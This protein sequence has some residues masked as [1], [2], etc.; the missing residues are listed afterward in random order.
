MEFTFD[1]ILMDGI[2]DMVFV[3]RV[4]RDPVFIYD[5]L[6]R[7]AMDGT[8][9]N[10][11]AVGK[12]IREVYKE[13]TGTFLFEQYNK[14][15]TSGEAV[16]YEDSYVSPNGERNYSKTK[17]TPLFDEQNQ[18]KQIVAVVKDISKEKN[19]RL[20]TEK[21]WGKLQ[22][23][24]KRY[25]SLFHHN[26]DAIILFDLNGQ[27]EDGNIACESVT[28]YTPQELVGTTLNS[29]VVKEDA[30]L[31]KRLFKQA[32][33]GTTK[34]SR[35]EIHNKS[36]QR[37]ELSLKVTPLIIDEQVTGIYGILR[38]ITDVGRLIKKLE[39][40]EERFRIIAEHAQDLITLLDD[41]GKIIYV[42]PSYKNILGF[43]HHEYIG[44]FFLH[45]VYPDDRMNMDQVVI[46]SIK[47]GESFT[48]Q[49]KQYN[50]KEEPIWCEAHGTPIFDNQG[51]FKH[52]VVLTRN[53]SLQ[54]EYERQ[55][56][57][58][59]LHDSLTGLPNR[60]LFKD[61]LANALKEFMEKQNG[62]AV[63]M[64]DV[65]H[66][67]NINDEMG[68]DIGDEV[69]EEF[70]KRVQ[71]TIRDCDIV[72]RLGGDEFVILLPGVGSSQNA[73]MI[74][75]HIQQA[76]Q[77]PWNLNGNS[78]KVTTSMG[79]AMAP[80]QGATPFSMLKNADIALYEAKNAGRNSYQLRETIEETILL[81]INRI[82]K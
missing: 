17:L 57:H 42:S 79:I 28:G 10:R 71:E 49:F 36:G 29:L 40:S 48:V 8:G 26:S 70:G 6:N 38:D 53:I 2:S 14:V 60:R 67:K 46:Q 65:D 23:S 62:L 25:Q 32:I 9:L 66:F 30:N 7:A 34:N 76:M 73:T 47:K 5:F 19:A 37:I 63:I 22:E 15:V 51:K 27:I 69:I 64:M 59:A 1:R 35:L 13:E 43:N 72:A 50:H 74:A 77:Q 31:L 44:K 80:A 41:K 78:L 45:N 4:E 56:K 39:E 11:D 54:K 52:M 68:H 24:N 55:L 33:S 12:S 21:T 61:R 75:E 20:E 16:I 81:S 18:C 58:F 3:V 82:E